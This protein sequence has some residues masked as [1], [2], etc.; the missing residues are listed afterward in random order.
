MPTPR[1]FRTRFLILPQFQL[2]LLGANLAVI[3]FVAGVTWYQ[4][5]SSFAEL[6]SAAGVSGVEAEF[7]Q[8]Y[9]AFQ[10]RNLNVALGVALATALVVSAVL[11]L[12]ISHRFSGPL[13]RLRGFFRDL[14]DGTGPAQKLS[15]RKDDFLDDLPPL[16]NRALDRMQGQARR[17]EPSK[18]AG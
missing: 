5:S 8:R 17:P 12:A 11:T 2:K 15:F 6:S 16:V 14:A 3:L 9:L 4:L 18:K 13:V 1:V 10:A 7:Y